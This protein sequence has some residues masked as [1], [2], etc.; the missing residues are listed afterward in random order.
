MF[1]TLFTGISGMNAMG[2]GLSVVGDNIAN[3]NTVGFKSS[4]V[5]FTD[6]L[7]STIQG[8]EGQIGRGVQVADIYKNYAQ[9]TFES[10]SNYLDLAVDGEGFFVVGD[11][12][13]KLFSRA[14]QFKL[15][16][17][18]RIVNAKGYVLQGYKSDDNG[19]VTQEVTDLLIAPKQKE[20][21]A[22]TKVTFGLNLDSRQKPPV[23]PVFD[24]KDAATY[25]YSSQ[26]VAYDSQGDAHQVT[27]YYVKNA[28]VENL[29]KTELLKDIDGFIK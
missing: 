25:N 7:G 16:R 1:N 15:D 8:G 19:V 27:A 12:G 6:I 5:S 28:G 4:K 11:K 10:S 22:T 20:A 29:D 13:K 21:R 26:F 14:G 3:M 2:K 23:N 18:G 9:G 17:E 24:N